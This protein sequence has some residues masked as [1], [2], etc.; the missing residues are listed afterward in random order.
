[1]PVYFVESSW[2]SPLG[3]AGE[4]KGLSIAVAAWE[5]KMQVNGSDPTLIAAT[6]RQ[7]GLR[8]STDVLLFWAVLGCSLN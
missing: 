8:F 5:V 4:E 2:T 6:S 7:Q 3:I 1:M